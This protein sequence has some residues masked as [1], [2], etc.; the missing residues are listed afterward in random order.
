MNGLHDGLSAGG[1]WQKLVVGQAKRNNTAVDSPE[2][3]P[4]PP[5]D[6][7]HHFS[8]VTVNRTGSIVKSFYKYFA[9]P[10][11]QNLAGGMC[12]RSRPYQRRPF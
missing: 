11:I 12:G 7:S 1:N 6:L 3:V 4:R 5:V 2:A 10:G 9:I 8:L